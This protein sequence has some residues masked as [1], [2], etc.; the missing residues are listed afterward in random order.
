M[1]THIVISLISSQN[2]MFQIKS[3]GGNQNTH[4]M[5]SNVFPKIVLCG[6]MWKNMKHLDRPQMTVQYGACALRAVQQTTDTLRICNTFSFSTAEIVTCCVCTH[7][8]THTNIY[9]YIY[10]Y[11]YIVVF[12]TRLRVVRQGQEIFLFS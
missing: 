10:I 11:I 1:N 2:E 3:C 8:R 9:I 4:I 12:V 6:I 5:F 7:T